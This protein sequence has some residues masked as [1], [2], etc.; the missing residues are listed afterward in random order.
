M[1]K[2]IRNGIVYAGSPNVEV[3]D[4]YTKAES[5][6]RYPSKTY[7]DADKVIVDD[8]NYEIELGAENNLSTSGIAIGEFNNVSNSSSNILIGYYNYCLS[9]MHGYRGVVIG[10]NNDISNYDYNVVIGSNISNSTITQ[11]NEVIIGYQHNP[12]SVKPSGEVYSRGDVS[13]DD[14]SGTRLNMKNMLEVVTGRAIFTNTAAGIQQV[15]VTFPRTLPRKPKVVMINW[16]DSVNTPAYM[17]Y[18]YVQDGS[19]TVSGF[20]ALAK[21]LTSGSNWYADYVAFY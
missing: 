9:Y 15:Q 2:I 6:A 3:I 17:D 19:I 7:F 20:T 5:D 1:G 12:M 18:V 8:V 16:C 10:Y 13:C 4:A 11:N 14:G 21:R